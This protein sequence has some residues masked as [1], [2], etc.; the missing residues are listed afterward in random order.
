MSS[1]TTS[2]NTNGVHSDTKS[3]SKANY[4]ALMAVEVSIRKLHQGVRALNALENL[5]VMELPVY[6][7]TLHRLSGRIFNEAAVTV[8]DEITRSSRCA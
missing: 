8:R 6:D 1:V 4:D 5:G 2:T 3:A 7:A